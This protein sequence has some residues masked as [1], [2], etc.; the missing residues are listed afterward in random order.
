M[1][2]FPLLCLSACQLECPV[3]KE[4]YSTGES[5]RQLPCLHCYHS[6][7]IVPW[8]QLVQYSIRF[9]LNQFHPAVNS[10]FFFLNTYFMKMYTYFDVIF[11]RF[12]ILRVYSTTP[13]LSAGKV[14]M[15]RTVVSSHLLGQTRQHRPYRNVALFIGVYYDQSRT[16]R[17]T[18]SHEHHILKDI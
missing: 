18:N 17:Y 13:V 9:Q 16:D 11:T 10:R 6:N 15:V 14:W 3:C 5:V 1:H 12:V 2:N 4:E 7:C 8:L